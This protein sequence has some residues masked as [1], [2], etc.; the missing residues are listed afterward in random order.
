MSDHSYKSGAVPVRVFLSCLLLIFLAGCG[1][2]PAQTGS[3]AEADTL[4]VLATRISACSRLYT[5]QYDLR[6]ILIFTDTTSLNGNFL[7]QHVK[8]NLPFGG[9]RIAIPVTATAK[10]YIDLGKL[11]KSDISRRGDRLEITLSDPEIVLT[12]TAV[13]HAGVKQKVG[14]LRHRFTDE[15]ITH[16]QQKG[17][18]ELI[19]SLAQTNILEDAKENAARV[20]VP[21]AVQCGYREENI[22]VTFRKSLSDNDLPGLIRQL[23]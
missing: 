2:K 23:D 20:I 7:N 13:D 21:L 5:S 8:V 11:K 16:I 9:R 1:K 10:A 12:A 15:E 18:A 6:K 17:R 19:K 14:M 22:T 3:K 4:T